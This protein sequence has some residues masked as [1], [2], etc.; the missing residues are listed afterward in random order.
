MLEILLELLLDEVEEMVDEGDKLGLF[1]INSANST[2][3]GT[4]KLCLNSNSGGICNDD[5]SEMDEGVVNLE[6]ITSD[7]V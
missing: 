5:N 3:G 2:E 7:L 4:R 6:S 1:S